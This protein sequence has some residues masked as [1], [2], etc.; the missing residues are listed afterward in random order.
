MT[1]ALVTGAGVGIGRSFCRELARTGHDV[2]LVSRDRGRLEEVARELEATH[3]VRTE[4]LPAD[5]ATAEGRDRV[6]ARLSEDGDRA[7]DLLVN[8]AGFGLKTS[9]FASDVADEQR[10]LAVM[11]E[12]VLVLTHAAGEAMIARGRGHIIN[13]SSVASYITTGSYSACKAFVTV[14]SQSLANDLRGTGV[15]ITALCPGF[16][17]TEF[18]ERMG[19]PMSD[20]PGLMWLDSDR[21]VRAAL[22][23]ARAGK[24]L[25][26]PGPLYKGVE[27]VT[28]VLPRG[29]MQRISAAIV[30]GGG[31]TR[32]RDGH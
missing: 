17:R 13:V 2:V 21:L 1:T 30:G 31:P 29:V 8:N 28:G 23:D 20:I 5:L 32:E 11:C 14:L 16:T 7:V 6:A 24:V 3:G 12:A 27:V 22:A 25:S 4:V 19:A 26:T 18:H 9:F 15:G 10:Q